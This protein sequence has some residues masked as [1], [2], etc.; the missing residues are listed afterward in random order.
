[1]LEKYEECFD[2]IEHFQGNR[3]NTIIFCNSGY[4]RSL[5]FICKYLISRHKNEV[6]DIDKALDIMLSQADK[7]NYTFIKSQVKENLLMLKNQDMTGF[8]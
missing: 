7:E 5:L 8:L 2:K 1:M 3:E 4:Q 6:P